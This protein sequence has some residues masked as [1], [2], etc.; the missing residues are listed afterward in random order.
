MVLGF[1]KKS[2]RNS[3]AHQHPQREIVEE[4]PEE[5]TSLASSKDERTPNNSAPASPIVSP[6]DGTLLKRRQ[7]SF[8]VKSREA[9][10][11]TVD[12]W[13]ESDE[14]T[15]SI[16]LNKIDEINCRLAFSFG[17]D[18]EGV[19]SADVSFDSLAA[20][21]DVE[22]VSQKWSFIVDYPED[23]PLTSL[24]GDRRMRISS[25]STELTEWAKRVNTQYSELPTLSSST[26]STA[27]RRLFHSSS[28][29]PSSP[30]VSRA[31][32]LL[33]QN[34]Q[35][36]LRMSPLRRVN[37]VDN[38]PSVVDEQPDALVQLLN[39]AAK[40]YLELFQSRDELEESFAS[41]DLDSRS[42]DFSTRS[43][44]SVELG[45]TDDF[46][47]ESEEFAHVL[48]T[49]E[50]KKRWSKKESQLREN[51]KVEEDDRKKR[52]IESPLAHKSKKVV[53]IFSSHGAS[54]ILAN[55]LLQIMEE[56]DELGFSAEAVDDN[57]YHWR[58]KL[59]NFDSSSAVGNQLRQIRR[60]F[61]YSYVELDVTF[62]MDLYPF[63]PPSVK[64]VRPRFLEFMMG[65]VTCMDV[66][67]LSNWN[68]V[69][70]M[71]SV[72]T[73]IRSMIREIGKIDVNDPSNSIKTHPD[74][75]YTELEYLLLRLELLSEQ[76]SRISLK[77][78]SG[79]QQLSELDKQRL[80]EKT[81]V[82]TPI[83]ARKAST[84]HLPEK[85]KST[86]AS[87]A[88]KSANGEDSPQYWAKGTGYGFSHGGK[89]GPKPVWDVQAYL[90]AQ[91]ERN[92]QTEEVF[93]GILRF[94]VRDSLPPGQYEILEQSCLLPVIESYLRNDSLLD[95]GKNAIVYVA[96]MGVVQQFTR[97]K[98]LV[99]LLDTLPLQS[100]SIY[101]LLKVLHRQA[102]VFIQRVTTEVSQSVE[103]EMAK[104][105]TEVFESVRKSV[106]AYR[107]DKS[108]PPTS[109]TT[110]LATP[111]Q[112][113]QVTRLEPAKEVPA[114][115]KVTPKAETPQE[116]VVVS[117]TTPEETTA[118]P[119][120]AEPPAWKPPP[121]TEPP[122]PEIISNGFVDLKA[123]KME[124]KSEKDLAVEYE[125]FLKDLQYDTAPIASYR[126]VST[127]H[128]LTH[129]PGTTISRSK[130]LRLAQ[131][132]GSLISS[133]PLNLSSSVFIR[134]DE[135]KMDLA[136]AMITGPSDTPYDS[137]C[138]QFD[139]YFPHVYPDGPPL[140]NLQT[141]GGG[142]VRFNPNLYNCGKVCLS[143][144]GTWSGAEGETWS[145]DT[146]TLL[147]VLVSIQSLIL[148]PMPYFNEPGYE[149]QMGNRV[150]D[151]QSRRYNEVI[152][153]ATVEIAMVGQLRN[154]SRGFEAM[155]KNHFAIKKDYVL[156]TVE[157]WIEEGK[158]SPAH[159]S[160]L[161]KA[162][163]DLKDELAKLGPP[164]LA[165]PDLDDI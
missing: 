44:K 32:V 90:A 91:K 107:G 144:L 54:G 135:E 51:Q 80:E 160:R 117:A 17:Y 30:A 76:E 62:T 115:P 100:A 156:A 48:E 45:E 52:N 27:R 36:N 131:E 122:P 128:Y 109:G 11:K 55:D 110:S 113:P 77:S 31:S 57:I 7:L 148:V 61:G 88:P 102:K 26:S 40:T 79:T 28:S 8:R 5:S 106:S 78:K 139:I 64:L 50:L 12:A 59:F 29:Q 120:K 95:M 101:S 72:L 145:K 134:V 146:S 39:I 60:K 118:E 67:K 141:T 158:S 19:G 93:Q 38:T 154:P 4:A 94:L 9:I 165:E 87:P 111:Q 138:F 98:A 92:A 1:L 130:I 164:V 15:A 63:F 116:I 81:K 42:M 16:Q 2:F 143:L 97:H 132:Q 23:Y 163:K 33:K 53:Q 89:N 34:S 162:Y 37:S 69:K 119:A 73:Q 124:V 125:K 65:R 58:V 6:R 114:S 21:R 20:E 129:E 18:F 3:G 14:E 47:L 137:G 127:H 155:I 24:D 66:L 159:H 86:P 126:G 41:I 13:I 82:I 49:L 142:S 96:I 133:L 35:G 104:S 149:R 153:V 121:P 136:Q 151:E 56:T 161:S 70:D 150:G 46:D 71:R 99:P 22:E 25:R 123:S 10:Q 157:K 43:F 140:V 103:L 68:P 84:A 108:K 147:Q 75:A 112:S 83:L 152:R 74:G 85:S 105:I